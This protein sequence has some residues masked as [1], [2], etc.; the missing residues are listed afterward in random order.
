MGLLVIVTPSLRGSQDRP[1]TVS[2]PAAPLICTVGL[3]QADAPRW[4]DAD[5]STN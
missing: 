4:L 5:V 2:D 3:G 1:E